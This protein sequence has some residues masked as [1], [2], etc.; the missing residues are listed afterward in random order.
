MTMVTSA[1]TPL[2]TIFEGDRLKMVAEKLLTQILL[3]TGSPVDWGSNASIKGNELKVFGLAT[4]YEST[5]E[6]YELDVDK[7]MRLDASHPLYLSP[8]NVSELLNLDKEYGFALEIIPALN[9]KAPL[10]LNSSGLWVFVTVKNH[11][12]QPVLGA[13]V[14][15]KLYWV[16]IQKGL[17]W[18]DPNPPNNEFTD[19]TG[20]CTFRFTDIS[21]TLQS[22]VIIVYVNNYGTR[23]FKAIPI[24]LETQKKILYPNGAGDYQNWNVANISSKLQAITDRNDATYIWTQQD[25]PKEK[26]KETFQ[27]TD[28]E[29]LYIQSV[30]AYARCKA[31][32][33]ITGGP[34]Q[35]EEFAIIWRTDNKDY[36]GTSFILERTNWKDYSETRLTNPS[37]GKPWTSEKVNNLQVGVMAKQPLEKKGGQTEEVRCSE[38]W[39][40]VE[41]IGMTAPSYL[42]GRTL[43]IEEALTPLNPSN[44]TVLEVLPLIRNGEISLREVTFPITKKGNIANGKAFTIYEIQHMES[45]AVIVLAAFQKSS[46]PYTVYASRQV[47]FSTSRSY[48]TIPGIYP[49]QRNKEFPLSAYAERIVKIGDCSYLV[50]LY[51]WRMSY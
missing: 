13:K 41:Y 1:V 40:E 18:K 9:I 6:A 3:S 44:P 15:A 17:Q 48:G 30:T 51:I 8:T 33:V 32:N 11:Q 29:E 27:F 50:R 14:I 12:D 20:T 47:D 46:M 16:D 5:R 37:T 35:R 36:E 28:I 38:L 34:D 45:S 26:A 25:T 19:E 42:S 23:N 2:R 21:G 10:K 43:F 39:L 22:G 24:L 49:G 7:V 4:Q 31:I